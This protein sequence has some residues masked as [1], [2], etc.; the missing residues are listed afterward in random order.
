[1]RAQSRYFNPLRPV[2]VSESIDV[3]PGVAIVGS[4][5]LALIVVLIALMCVMRLRRKEPGDQ[6][7]G[8]S[9]SIQQW[10]RRLRGQQPVP[11]DEPPNLPSIL[12]DQLVDAYLERVKENGFQM[13]FE[14]LLMEIIT[15]YPIEYISAVI[16]NSVTDLN[17]C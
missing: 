2:R 5:I 8:F 1:M 3:V 12:K 11:S 9:H 13:E 15:M 7:L 6:E 17:I 10:C 16:L 4:L 14:V